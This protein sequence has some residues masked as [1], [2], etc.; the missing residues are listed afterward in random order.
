MDIRTQLDEKLWASIETAYERRD[1][2]SAILDS[3]YYLGNYIREKTGLESD[4]VPLVLQAFG[5]NSPKLRVNALQTESEKN[6][7]KGTQHLLMGLFTSIRNPR[8]HEKYDDTK[9]DADSIILFVNYLLGIIGAS[10]GAFSKT[11]F[12]NRV[13]DKSF[14]KND[15]YAQLLVDEVPHRYIFDIMVDVYR[16]KQEGELDKLGLFTKTLLSKFDD[17]DMSRLAEIISGELKM[18]DNDDSVR[19]TLRMFPAKFWGRLDEI[20]RMRS[21][22]R[23][24]ESIK[25]G[26]YSI[27]SKTCI[28]GA[29]GTWCAGYIN[30]FTMKEECI[31]CLIFKL[32]SSKKSEQDYFFS[33]FESSLLNHIDNSNEEYLRQW[34]SDIIIEGL[35]TGDKRFYEFAQNAIKYHAAFW[36]DLLK[37]PFD[38]FHETVEVVTDKTEDLPF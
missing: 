30:N 35:K 13:F 11:E 16:R 7:Q 19:L 9:E 8:S 6:I 10:K 26:E 12:L 14:V 36:N 17:D 2:T 18:T 5:G 4:G 24:L 33:F 21:E 3:L 29:L 1:F 23:F 37:D 15:K 31:T 28:R 32:G 34:V 27:A 22:N 25:V 20:A 38:S